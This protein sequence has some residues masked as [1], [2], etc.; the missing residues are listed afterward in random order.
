[1]GGTMSEVYALGTAALAIT[2]TK[3]LA[4]AKAK[5]NFL[6]TYFKGNPY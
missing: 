2:G 1:M 6:S 3:A 4:I 5:V